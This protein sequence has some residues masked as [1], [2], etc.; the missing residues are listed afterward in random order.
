M[1][2]K[3][4]R[5]PFRD[6]AKRPQPRTARPSQ[7]VLPLTPEQQAQ[8]AVLEALRTRLGRMPLREELPPYLRMGLAASFGSLGSAFRQADRISPSRSVAP[9]TK[10]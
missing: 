10:S 3:T 8:L 6:W 1:Q 5:H 7:P 9:E 4:Q 2:K